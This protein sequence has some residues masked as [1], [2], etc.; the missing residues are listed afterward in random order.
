MTSLGG[1]AKRISI[2]GSPCATD[3]GLLLST[4]IPH[5]QVGCHPAALTAAHHDGRIEHVDLSEDAVYLH[6]G[7]LHIPSQRGVNYRHEPGLSAQVP[8]RLWLRP[9]SCQTCAKRMEADRRGL[10]RRRSPGRTLRGGAHSGGSSLKNARSQ[11]DISSLQL[12]GV[13]SNDWNGAAVSADNPIVRRKDKSVL[14]SNHIQSCLHCGPVKILH[15]QD[16]VAL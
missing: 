15:Q 3:H 4:G 12:I 13:Q 10:A 7:P 11:M 6:I 1:P 14:S 5:H 2:L 9:S 8:P 16:D